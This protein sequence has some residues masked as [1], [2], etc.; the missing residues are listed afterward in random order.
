MDSIL[1]HIKY[2]KNFIFIYVF[3][4]QSSVL[5]F[6]EEGE[7]PSLTSLSSILSR[8][9]GLFLA[10]SAAA[11][12]IMV[13]YGIIK[14]SLAAGDPRGLEG[15]KSTWTYA[16]Y[17]FLIVV[18]SMVIL[19]LIRKILGLS[20]GSEEFGFKTFLDKIFDSIEELVGV[21]QRS[22]LGSQGASEGYLPVT[23]MPK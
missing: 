5:S 16:L 12:I 19:A 23:P 22:G 2:H 20:T 3:L 15:A 10:A 7:P 13:G 14:G 9:V 11:L 8:I 21:G 18:L 1:K 4:I 6:A 17:G